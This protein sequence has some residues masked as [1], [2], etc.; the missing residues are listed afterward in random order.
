MSKKT[1]EFKNCKCEYYCP[2]SK[3]KYG[4]LGKT[5]LPTFHSL[6]VHFIRIHG[7]KKHSCRRC[8]KSFSIKSELERH[9][10]TYVTYFLK[11]NRFIYKFF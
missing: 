4:L 6:K 3:C 7:D 1:K 5:S 11:L 2:V 10:R 8:S 9:E